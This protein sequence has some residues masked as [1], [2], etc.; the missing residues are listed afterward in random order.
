M[1]KDNYKNETDGLVEG[2][3]L[4]FHITCNERHVDMGIEIKYRKKEAYLNWF[5]KWRIY[6]DQ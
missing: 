4:G 1:V 2:L 5:S 6:L 3:Q